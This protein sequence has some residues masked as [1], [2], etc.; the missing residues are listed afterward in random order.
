[1]DEIPH[2]D[3][4]VHPARGDHPVGLPDIQGHRPGHVTYPP[5]SEAHPVRELRSGA[6][7][8]VAPPMQTAPGSADRFV[9]LGTDVPASR[10]A[11]GGHPQVAPGLQGIGALPVL[12]DFVGGRGAKL[13]L[14][15]GRLGD[16]PEGLETFT[17]LFK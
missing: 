8:Y 1:M 5:V 17:C 10:V 2:P 3:R 14:A 13:A 9:H 7:G 4:G 11:P 6:D 16:T 15:H 12:R